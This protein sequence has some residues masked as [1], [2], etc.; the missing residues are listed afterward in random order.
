MSTHPLPLPNRGPNLRKPLTRPGYTIRVA[1]LNCNGFTKNNPHNRHQL[2]W[3][4]ISKN[5]ID[6]L[7][8]IDHRTSLR[9]LNLLKEHGSSHLN[10]DI[11]LIADNIT[12]LHQ[13]TQHS[14]PL[15]DYH[16]TV[17]GCAILA[18]GSL[19]HVTF[20]S[21]F[22]DPSGAGTFIGAKIQPHSSLPPVFL[23]AIYL[24][25]PSP[26]PS[27]LNSRIAQYLKETKQNST[28]SRWQLST[29]T[30]LL[31]EQRD[32]F[33]NCVQI[34]GGDFN[35]RKWHQMN[36]PTTHTFLTKLHLINSAFDAV[37]HLNDQ[38]ITPIT[39]PSHNSWIDHI[40]IAGRA[41][42][43]DFTDYR[44][45]LVTTYTDHVPY[46]ND[47]YIHLPTLH[48]NI[49]RNL[50]SQAKKHLKAVH[51][52]KHDTISRE[53]YQSICLKYLNTLTPDTSH[54]SITDHDNHYEQVCSTLLTIAKRAT[55]HTIRTS[56]PTTTKWS[57]EL[58]FLYKFI[59]LLKRLL[60]TPT[61]NS[62]PQTENSPS[63]TLTT[64]HQFLHHHYSATKI[65]NNVSS[66]RYH[67]IITKIFP[68][69][70][71]L[72]PSPTLPLPP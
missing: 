2:L 33:P 15:Y 63:T 62:P 16:A 13:P 5:K 54:W 60:A 38:S 53:R 21:S 44:Q 27:T 46:S 64:I 39:F 65:V 40:L 4:F 41:E 18:F 34:V 69:Y 50:H 32:A 43:R 29:I 14:A 10:T 71:Y 45:D 26:G 59:K 1:T 25:P 23:N 49:P 9:S 68:N 22:Q 61:P 72:T 7:F 37:Q 52:K 57:P 66:P 35:H 55:K 56:M 19:A 36:H 67:N 6:I 20:P 28:P 58:S 12:L 70:P 3:D 24:F 42:I 8:L 30:S 47:I 31:E 51:I 48:Y 11:R 17:G